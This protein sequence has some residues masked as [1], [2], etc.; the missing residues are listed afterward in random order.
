MRRSEVSLK[1][2]EQA[3]WLAWRL[4]NILC[5]SL[6][7]WRQPRALASL[8]N[9]LPSTV[10]LVADALAARYDLKGW[11]RACDAQGFRESLYVLDVL[12]RYAGS[13]DAM[14]PGLDIGCKNGCY[15]PGLQ[16]W[17]GG[18]WDGVELDAHRRYWTLT[19]RRAHGEWV[20]HALPECRY[21][22]GN[23]LDLHDGYGFITW[24]LPFLHAAPLREWG[25]PVRFLMPRRLLDHAW[26]LLAPGGRLLVINQGESEVERQAELFEQAGIVARAL[27]RIESPLSPFQRRRYGFMA[28][29]P[30]T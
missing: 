10:R 3:R 26:T 21:L 2:C 18:P 29:R 13:P 16:A 8:L 25:L 22:A 19:T 11:E 9:T 7:V 28:C 24:F 20:A 27:G 12:D 15:L 23:L 14:R 4:R 30:Y 5:W 1:P 6:P 17:S